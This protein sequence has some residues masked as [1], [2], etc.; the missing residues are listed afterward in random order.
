[1][2]TTLS[3]L[4]L[5]EPLEDVQMVQTHLESRSP[6][7]PHCWRRQLIGDHSWIKAMMALGVHA[8]KKVEPHTYIQEAIHH[9]GWNGDDQPSTWFQHQ[10]HR[11]EPLLAQFGRHVLN[12][13]QHRDGIKSVGSVEG[14]GESPLFELVR[15][16]GP[17]RWLVWVD[18]DAGFD[19]R[20]GLTK[21]RTIG[22]SDV[23]HMAAGGYPPECFGD[24]FSLQKPINGIHATRQRRGDFLG[25]APAIR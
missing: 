5:G 14:V 25:A 7:E 11:L 3:S 21:Q 9:R 22:T 6:H 16:G 20:V 4:D 23:K 12:D 13:G 8:I 19:L 10:H 1:M 18:T 24:A 2:Y 15:T 17:I